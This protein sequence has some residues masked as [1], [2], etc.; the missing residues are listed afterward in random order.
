MNSN[1]HKL[2]IGATAMLTSCSL[3][4]QDKKNVLFIA[5]DDLKPLINSYGSDFMHTPNIDMLAEKGVLFTNAHCQQAVCGPSRASLLTGMRPDYTGVWDLKTRMRDIN[6]DILALPQ[7]FRQ[8]GYASV[9]VG[10]IYD[11]RSVA[12]EYD[13]QSWSI[14]YSES[15]TYVYPEEYGEPALSFYAKAESKEIVKKLTQEA[16]STGADNVHTYVSERYKPSTECADVPDEAYMDG[17]ICNNALGYM[18]ELAGKDEPF[19][20]AVGF[21]RPHLPFAAPKKYW[22]LYDR[23]KVQLAE[24][25]KPV[26]D[27]VSI[28]YHNHGELQSYSDIPVLESFSDIFSNLLTEEKQRELIHGYYASIS[29]ID[30]QIG[31]LLS[32]LK[33]LGLE[34]NTI[35]VLWGDHGWH[36]GDHA[37]WCKH[38][39]F[40]QATRVPFIISSPGSKQGEYHYPVEFVDIFPTL[41]DANGLEIP[42]QLQGASLVP[43]LKNLNHKVKEYAVSQFDRGPNHGYSLRNDRYRLTI[44]MQNNYRTFMPFDEKLVL[45][46]ELYDY[47]ADPNETINLYRSVQHKDITEQMFS[48]FKEFVLRQNAELENS[49]SIA[50]NK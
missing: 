22:D 13:F 32:Q 28:A 40:E 35:I 45:D 49:G 16:R 11:P 23:D 14:P 1:I 41:C 9:A 48:Y 31:K 27:G 15:S 39:N 25:Q 50:N 29:F 2:L 26:K 12:E 38:T 20:L 10:K 8:N 6:P 44:W 21:K 47:V 30:A 36:L 5:V 24:Y 7:Y 43:A 19:F 17:Q 42:A 37:L 34:E 33:E 18:K 3:N 4:S 46:C